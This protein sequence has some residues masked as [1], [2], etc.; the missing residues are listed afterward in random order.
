MHILVSGSS[1][2]IGSA[3]V[4]SLAAEGHRVSRLVRSD[5]KP[6]SGEVRWDP[7][8]GL[9]D[10]SSLEGLE[11]IIHLA[12]DPIAQGRWTPEKKAKIRDSRVNGTKLLSEALARLKQP[13]K[14]LACA[15]AIG[16][17]G[18]RSDQILQE[19]SPP[20]TGFLAQTCQEWEKASESAVQR[21]IRV[22]HLRFGIVLS[23]KGGALAM[24]LPI[25]Q[26]GLGGKLGNGKHWMS[27][28]ALDDVVGAIQHAVVT[29]RLRGP[30]NAVSPNPVTNAEFTRA[31]GN[32][33]HRP[34]FFPVP[35]F[36]LRLLFGEMA[37][38]ALLA[39]AKV[40][41][42]RLAGSGY[43]FRYPILEEALHHLLGTKP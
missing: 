22:V 18:D 29:E 16:Y 8:T 20:G 7:A 14:V 2:L 3:L 6:S 4:S 11:T 34:T 40:M 38:E 10:A 15:S 43:R 24:M 27:W 12:G 31:L 19:D 26:K 42:V 33:L 32:I 21:G 25:F 36:G 37:N 39:S 9:I 5:P 1:G 13:P 35:A 17:Y 23:P 30:V 41:P 28:I